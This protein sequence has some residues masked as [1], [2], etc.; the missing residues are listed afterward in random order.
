MISTCL[1]S[2][3][4]NQV[5]LQL[6]LEANV[7]GA[8]RTFPNL[9]Y[10]FL[11]QWTVSIYV[12]YTYLLTIMISITWDLKPA[13]KNPYKFI[14]VNHFFVGGVSIT[15]GETRKTQPGFFQGW[16]HRGIGY[17]AT[18]DDPWPPEKG[19]PSYGG[20]GKKHRGGHPEEW[21]ENPIV[22]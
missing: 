20:L 12:L 19:S 2:C 9:S 10:A 6:K 16:N 13:N 11:I 15:S 8:V 21:S 5:H 3:I 22:V 18:L 4:C 1:G 14:L 7:D 17:G